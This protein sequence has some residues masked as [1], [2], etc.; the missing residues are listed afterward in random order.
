VHLLAVPLDAF[1]SLL[2]HF[3]DM[4]RELQLI[5][6]GA[7]DEG[8]APR[9]HAIAVHTQHEVARARN[10]LHVQA[11]A[12]LDAQ[13]Q[14]ADLEVDLRPSAVA[15]S[16]SLVPLIDSFDE[17]SRSGA[18]LTASCAPAARRVLEW[19][20]EEVDSQLMTDRAPRAFPA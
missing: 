16:H 10:D 20:V 5:A 3:D 15:A 1:V 6:V 7:N 13:Q 9:L 12:A 17:M 8:A 19:I 11:R 18:V 4:V 2:G 14:V